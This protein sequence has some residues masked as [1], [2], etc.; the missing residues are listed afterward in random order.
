MLSTAQPACMAGTR[1]DQGRKPASALGRPSSLCK[2][3][4]CTPET[5]KWPIQIQ[6]TLAA[7]DRSL[8]SQLNSHLVP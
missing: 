2:A 4:G 5:Y 1:H 8:N 6:G 7:M 3:E